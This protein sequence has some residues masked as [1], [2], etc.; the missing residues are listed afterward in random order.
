MEDEEIRVSL[1]HREGEC[2][3]LDQF[4][5]QQISSTCCGVSEKAKC[6]VNSLEARV[7]TPW[8]NAFS[9]RHHQRSRGMYS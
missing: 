2:G 8:R 3:H 5:K 4:A 6:L 9:L 7:A 1:L